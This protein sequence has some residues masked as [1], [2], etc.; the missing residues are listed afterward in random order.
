VKA[1]AV[2]P[3]VAAFFSPV[4]E[5]HRA[6]RSVFLPA[7]VVEPAAANFGYAPAADL[8]TRKL[9]FVEVGSWV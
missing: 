3:I 9:N 6:P 4:E 8:L 1:A 2:A 5:K 7:A